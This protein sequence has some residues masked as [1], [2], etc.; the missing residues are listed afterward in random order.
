MK[1]HSIQKLSYE[2]GMLTN[3]TDIAHALNMHFCS[4]GYR[5]SNNIPDTMNEYKQ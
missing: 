3:P 1:S 5:L 2:E 4:I